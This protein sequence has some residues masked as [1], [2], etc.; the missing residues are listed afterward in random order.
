MPSKVI[1]VLEGGGAMCAYECGAYKA[2]VEYLQAS[3]RTLSVVAGA[4]MG[5]VNAGIIARHYHEADH[6]AGA[7]EALWQ[8]LATPSIP[9]I[10]LPADY[11]QRWNALLTALLHGNPGV[12]TPNF[13]GWSV[14]GALGRMGLPLYDS[15]AMQRT[16][17]THFGE[18]ATL[19]GEEPLLVVTAVDIER[20]LPVAFNSWEEAVTPEKIVASGSI[21][22]LYPPRQ[23]NGRYHWDGDFWSNT[24]LRDV[25]NFLQRCDDACHIAEEYEVIMIDLYQQ[26]GPVPQTDLQAL[27]RLKDIVFGDKADYDEKA[28]RLVNRYIDF[29]R[30]VAAI[31]AELPSSPLTAVIE[32]ERQRIT[33]EKRLRLDFKRIDRANLP[34][35]H[36]SGMFDY[37]PKRLAALIAQG[38]ENALARL[39][40]VTPTSGSKRAT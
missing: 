3:G 10:P 30:E 32:R 8:E 5:A 39:S 24:C 14:A 26:S 31:G 1:L 33:K 16:L 6:G 11:W 9:F 12:H 15:D 29:V 38:Y 27:H 7:L 40:A 28:S 4:S 22:I 17:S 34:D 25:L 37:S 2:I 18:Y 21:P 36:V 20:G 35:E 23:I 13:A 19:P